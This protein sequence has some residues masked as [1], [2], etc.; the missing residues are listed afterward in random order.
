MITLTTLQSLIAEGESET[1]EL[2]RSTA[3]L[4]RAAYTSLYAKDNP[5]SRIWR[6]TAR[7]G[8]DNRV[9][10]DDT[11]RVLEYVPKGTKLVGEVELPASQLD[12][13]KRL[14]QEVDALCGGRSTGAGRVKLSLSEVASTFEGGA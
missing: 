11:L 4:K 5:E 9:P 8:F 10:N 7:E 2:K 14:A 12:T 13:L 3:E 6:S 1:L